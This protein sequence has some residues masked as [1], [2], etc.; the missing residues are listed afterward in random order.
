MAISGASSK[1]CAVQIK[2]GDA[3][4][5]V[6]GGIELQTEILMQTME[7]TSTSLVEMLPEKILK[8]AH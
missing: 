1:I 7:Q 2:T 5:G 6:A 4:N 3:T 8:A